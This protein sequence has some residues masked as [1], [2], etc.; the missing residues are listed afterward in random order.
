MFSCRNSR[1]TFTADLS[2]PSPEPR[3]NTPSRIAKWGGVDAKITRLNPSQYYRQYFAEQ[4]PVAKCLH[5]F[6]TLYWLYSDP[7]ILLNKHIVSQIGDAAQIFQHLFLQT[8]QFYMPLQGLV[9]CPI[10]TAMPV[11]TFDPV[12]M[13]TAETRIQIQINYCLENLDTD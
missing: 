5:T 1:R 11:G 7:S 3:R 10:K 13:Q 2:I 9:L 4:F 12:F 8:T 6:L